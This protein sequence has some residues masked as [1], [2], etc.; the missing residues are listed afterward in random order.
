MTGGT[1]TEQWL[2]GEEKVRVSSEVN[3]GINRVALV[4]SLGTQQAIRVAPRE[5]GDPP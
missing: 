5:P 4:K 1:I 2:F 3:D